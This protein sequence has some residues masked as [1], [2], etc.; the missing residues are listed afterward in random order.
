MPLLVSIRFFKDLVFAKMFL[1]NKAAEQR[2][3]DFRWIFAVAISVG[4][5][6]DNW[7]VYLVNSVLL[8]EE[9]ALTIL[10]RMVLIGVKTKTI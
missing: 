3:T 6:V 9:I 8:S 1:K 5:A 7:R 4:S 10:R 2:V